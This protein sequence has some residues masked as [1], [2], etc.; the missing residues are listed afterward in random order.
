MP[1]VVPFRPAIVGNHT[2]ELF[3]AEDNLRGVETSA[4]CPQ[5]GKIGLQ[6]RQITH[7]FDTFTRTEAVSND[8][9]VEGGCEDEGGVVSVLVVA[10]EPLPGPVS[11]PFCV[12][13]YKMTKNASNASKNPHIRKI[14][15]VAKSYHEESELRVCF[16]LAS[17][18]ININR[19]RCLCP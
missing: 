10:A 9:K 11:R 13:L 19:R 16:G 15:I 2:F 1:A 7:V 5:L 17:E 12:I 4:K 6:L 14:E 3:L 8:R 18:R